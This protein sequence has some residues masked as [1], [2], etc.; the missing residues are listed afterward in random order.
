MEVHKRIWR[1]TWVSHDPALVSPDPAL[2]SHDLHSVTWQVPQPCD[3]YSVKWPC[4][5]GHMTSVVS[6]DPTPLVMWPPVCHLATPRPCDLAL[7]HGSAPPATDPRT[8]TL[9]LVP[10]TKPHLPNFLMSAWRGHLALLW[11]PGFQVAADF[12]NKIISQG[13]ESKRKVRMGQGTEEWGTVH[14]KLR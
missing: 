5:Q 1:Q 3:L 8:W 6:H 12:M 14:Q 9:A 7:S 13:I 2:R 4:P 10:V 11:Q